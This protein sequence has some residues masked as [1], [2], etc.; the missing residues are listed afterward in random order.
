MNTHNVAANMMWVL[1]TNSKLFQP[2]IDLQNY[3]LSCSCVLVS[4]LKRIW[5]YRSN[6]SPHYNQVNNAYYIFIGI[7]MFYR[8]FYYSQIDMDHGKDCCY[9]I[10]LALHL[11]AY[12]NAV[13]NHH[14]KQNDFMTC[15]D[16]TTKNHSFWWT[17]HKAILMAGTRMCKSHRPSIIIHFT[18]PALVIVAYPTRLV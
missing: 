15:P 7:H 12:I 11:S 3:G 1:Q 17:S 9:V 18:V 10:P 16:F 14:A 5:K 6:H 2:L 13:D 8:R 4:L